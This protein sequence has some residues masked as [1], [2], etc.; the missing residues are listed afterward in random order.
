VRA[1]ARATLCGPLRALA[2]RG[3]SLSFEEHVR[4]TLPDGRS[5]VDGKADL[6]ARR[7][8]VVFVVELKSSRA[9]ADSAS[10]RLQLAAYA[11]ALTANGAADVRTASLVLGDDLEW[12]DATRYDARA[13]RAL[14]EAVLRNRAIPDPDAAFSNPVALLPET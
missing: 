5:V 14:A 1:R 13:A 4:G 6:I 8:G 11:A 9:A 7:D 3:F 12:E 2:A 10:T